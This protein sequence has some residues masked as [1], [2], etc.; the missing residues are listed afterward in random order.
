M[1]YDEIFI[2]NQPI[3]S[4]ILNKINNSENKVHAYMLVGDSKEKLKE[5]TTLFSKVLVC[6]NKYIKN[7]NKCNICKRIEDNLYG[8]LKILEPVNKTIKK[9]EV[10]KLRNNFKTESIEGKN[11]VYI[12]NDI[13]ALNIAAANSIL[14]FLE[15]PDSNCIA[16][17]TTTNL[18]A[19]I[20]TISSRCQIIKLNSYEEQKGI[21]FVKEVSKL[22]EPMIYDIINYVN[23]VEL[24][25]S[26]AVAEAKT[27]FISTFDNNESLV[28]ALNVMLLYYKDMLNYKIQG[29]FNYFDD[30]Y[31]KTIADM[32]S[33]KI[34]T[35]K[36]SFI[37]EN[38]S[39]LEYNVNVALFV[40]NFLIGIGEISDGKSN[41]N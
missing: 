40:I 41:R 22:E 12:I 5:C 36:I 25:F 27:Y 2:E 26:F 23:K 6:P 34:I 11:N 21:E 29:A 4:R 37:L 17:F 30:S 13:E 10:L 7:C 28:S 24:N 9:E 31:I 19:V 14:K 39:K 8:E 38:I 3:L 33:K 1:N 18:D 16:I 35:K 15:E 20:K 32:M